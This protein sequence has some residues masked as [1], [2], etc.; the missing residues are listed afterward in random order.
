MIWDIDFHCFKDYCLFQ[1]TFAKMQIQDLTTKEFKLKK[2][3][4]KDSKPSNKETSTSSCI[5]ESEK[6]FY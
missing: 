5:D 2:F 1:N 4:F 6:T 3:R